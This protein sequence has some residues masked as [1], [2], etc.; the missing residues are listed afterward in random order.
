VR[1]GWL[2]RMLEL[3]GLKSCDAVSIHTYLYSRPGRG[4]SPE[5]WAAWM[6]EVQRLLMKYSGGTE[7]PLYITEMG[8]PTHSGDRG[9]ARDLSADYLARM[10]LLARTM[11]FLKGIW[12]YDFQDD[13]WRATYNEHNFG[14]VRADLTPKPSYHSF[15]SVA[16]LVSR[17]SSAERLMAHDPDLWVLKINTEGEPSSIALWSADD[18]KEFQVLLRHPGETPQGELQLKPARGEAMARNWG[19][20]AWTESRRNVAANQFSIV[21]GREPLLISGDLDGV[22]IENTIPRPLG[23]EK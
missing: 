11:P 2:E 19:H 13:G 17:S 12:W 9:M 18:E 6:E 21:A 23:A 8:W 14:L 3:G 1:G 7:I 20:R 16:G 22:Q 15:R 4:R 10:F 5:T